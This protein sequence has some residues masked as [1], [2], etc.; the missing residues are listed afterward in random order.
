MAGTLNTAMVLCAGLG[1]RMAPADNG[2][3]KPLVPVRG[4]ALLDH[5]LDRLAAAG[6]TRAV[7]NV[8]HKA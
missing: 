1:T 2:R 4:K 3:P 7:I 6:F 5:V 8:H